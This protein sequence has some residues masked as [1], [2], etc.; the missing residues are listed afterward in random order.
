MLCRGAVTPHGWLPPACETDTI[1]RGCSVSA[2]AT[3]LRSLPHPSSR[4]RRKKQDRIAFVA[5]LTSTVFTLVLNLGVA[6][7]TKETKKG[8]QLHQSPQEDCL[9]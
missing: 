2:V 9:S 5:I 4:P 3:V 7:S 8:D 1:L 6:A